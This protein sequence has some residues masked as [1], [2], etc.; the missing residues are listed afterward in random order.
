MRSISGTLVNLAKRV[1]CRKL[2]PPSGAISIWVTVCPNVAAQV[3][4]SSI[5]GGVEKIGAQVVLHHE[6]LGDAVG[7]RRRG[8]EGNDPLAVALLQIV[9][10]HVQV[11]RAH[12]SVDGRV[13]DI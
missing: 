1:F 11:G 2:L 5:P 13:G 6:G 3:S 4:K 12:G 9:D 8:G 10:L 7:D